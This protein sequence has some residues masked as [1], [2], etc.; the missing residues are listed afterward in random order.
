[1]GKESGN[2]MGVT[3][4]SPHFSDHLMP[5]RG[6]GG[7]IRDLWRRLWSYTSIGCYDPHTYGRHLCL[8][9]VGDTNCRLC[10]VL[11]SPVESGSALDCG[12]VGRTLW[13]PKG[14]LCPRRLGKAESRP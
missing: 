7:G 2:M 1:M 11:S 10:I 4:R 8:A 14:I 3:L 13:G 6:G 12:V 9:E 5:V